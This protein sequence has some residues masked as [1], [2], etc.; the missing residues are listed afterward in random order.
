MILSRE[1]VLLF[2]RHQVGAVNGEQRLSLP[3]KLV[4]RIGKHFL[5]PSWKAYLNIGQP[6]FVDLDIAD[7]AY[8]IVNRLGLHNACLYANALQA[9]WRQ[10]DWDERRFT[11]IRSL[12]ADL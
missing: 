11:R 6:G 2:R 9:L 10:L 1:Q 3:D 8:L 4:S 5:N 12:V 7:G